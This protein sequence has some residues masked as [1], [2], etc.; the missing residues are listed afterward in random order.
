MCV[1]NAHCA[2]L[3]LQPFLLGPTR[4]TAEGGHTWASELCLLL[5]APQEHPAVQA[6]STPRRTFCSQIP[7][8]GKK[9]RRMESNF[10]LP[11]EEACGAGMGQGLGRGQTGVQGRKAWR[12]RKYISSVLPPTQG[13]EG[14][15]PL[16]SPPLGIHRIRDLVLSGSLLEVW[17]A[18]RKHKT[19][20]PARSE[21]KS[22]LSAPWLCGLGRITQPLLAPVSSSVKWG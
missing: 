9:V 5:C 15:V 19:L 11:M 16:Q 22:F 12:A 18:Y 13:E 20:E 21:S 17:C 4:S 10:P 2:I 14:P 1:C 3:L 8:L 6:S 7:G